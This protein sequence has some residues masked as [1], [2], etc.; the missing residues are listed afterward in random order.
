MDYFG[1]LLVFFTVRKQAR[2]GQPGW[3]GGGMILKRYGR[4]VLEG[5]ARLLIWSK[6]HQMPRWM[7]GYL[8]SA[9]DCT[10]RINRYRVHSP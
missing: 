8:R 2:I 6:I 1:L 7:V 9:S 4:R 5:G 3:E 10:H